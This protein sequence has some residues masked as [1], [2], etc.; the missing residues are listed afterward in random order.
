MRNSA[1]K[2]RLNKGSNISRLRTYFCDDC[3]AWHMTSSFH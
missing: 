2:H 3:K 1:T